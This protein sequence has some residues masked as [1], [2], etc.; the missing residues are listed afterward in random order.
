MIMMEMNKATVYL[1]QLEILKLEFEL[2][3]KGIFFE[4]C[5][6]FANFFKWIFCLNVTKIAIEVLS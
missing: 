2:A 5:V 4:E 6:L 3:S 1:Y